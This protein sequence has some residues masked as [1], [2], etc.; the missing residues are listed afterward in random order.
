MFVIYVVGD[1]AE[2]QQLGQLRILYEARGRRLEELDHEYKAFKED[3]D[4]E[5]RILKHRLTLTEGN[6]IRG[7]LQFEE[8]FCPLWC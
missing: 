4:R 8:D 1:S 5:I 3:S 6:T 2:G 7:Y